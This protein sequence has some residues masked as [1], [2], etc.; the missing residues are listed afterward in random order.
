MSEADSYPTPAPAPD[1]LNAEWYEFLAA[2]ELRF[3]YCEKCDRWQHPPRFLC[4]GCGSADWIWKAVAGRGVV[5][6]WTVTHKALH[7]M[8]ADVVPYSILVVELDEGPRIV[9]SA[10]G[11]ANEDLALDMP[12]KISIAKVNDK[13]GLP[14]AERVSP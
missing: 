10:R 13:V 1:G 9:C 5:F 8:F 6:S 11:I 3:Q 7:P 12:V 4:A 2:G 14:Y